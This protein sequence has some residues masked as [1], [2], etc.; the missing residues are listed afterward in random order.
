MANSAPFHPLNP[1]VFDRPPRRGL[2]CHL[3]T[4][5]LTH[6]R[7]KRHGAP[8]PLADHVILPLEVQTK[9][10]DVFFCIHVCVYI[11]TYMYNHIYIHIYK[12]RYP[13]THTQVDLIMVQA[14]FAFCT[15]QP[16][17]VS[18]WPSVHW[19][20]HPL[21]WTRL[22]LTVT[23]EGLGKRILPWFNGNTTGKQ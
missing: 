23:V 7:F 21:R 1:H 5:L 8:N 4:W 11:Y 10:D 6:G 17:S 3:M 13:D 2:C 14:P 20:S 16:W 19:T 12:R 22:R 15:A 9:P 18:G